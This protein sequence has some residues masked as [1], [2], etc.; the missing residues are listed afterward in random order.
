[1]RRTASCALG[2]LSIVA[3]L[4]LGCGGKHGSG[5]DADTLCGGT[6]CATGEVCRYDRCIAPPA[7]CVNGACSG[8]TCCDTGANECL[9]YGLGPC[10]ANDTACKHTPVPG[11]FFPGVQC[12]WL[13]PPAGDKY[14]DHKNV[15]STPMVATLNGGGAEFTQPWIVF[16]SYNFDDGGDESCKGIDPRYFGVIRV[17]DGRDCAQIATID[18]P[19]VVASSSLALADIGGFDAFPEFIGARTDGGLAAWSRNPATGTWELLWQTASTVGNDVCD[20]AG[21]SV[22]DLD[23]DGKPEILFLGSVFD[24]N[25]KTLDESLTTA[26][27][28]PGANG[29]IPVVADVDGDGGVELVS[30]AQLY[31]WDIP[32]HK[33]VVKGPALGQAGRVAVADLGTYGAVAAND[34][35]SKLDGVA[36]VVVI[37]APTP[38]QGHAYVYNLAGRKVFEAV[39]QGSPPG[40]GG[41]PTVADFD[42]DGRAEFASAGGTAYTVFDPDC[43]AGASAANCASGRTDGVLW[44]QPSQDKSSNVTG[45]SVFDFDGDGTAEVVYG[46]E[47][48]TRVYNGKTGDVEY[49][50][51][52]RSCTWF[53]NPVIADVDADYNAEIL[54]PSNTNCPN[55]IT[56]PALDPIFDGVKCLDDADCPKATH[57]GRD[58]SGDALGKCRCTADPDC[59]GDNF[60]CRDPIAGPAAAGKVC[61]AENPGPSTAFG[62]RVISD[63]LDRWGNTRPIWNQHAYSVTNISDSGIVP[64]TSQWVRNWT[65]A[66]LNNFRQNAPSAD[67]IPGASPDLTVHQ[68]KA[69]CTGPDGTVTVEICDRGTEP[70][71]DGIKISV[72]AGDPPGALACVATT[73]TRVFPGNCVTASCTWANAKGSATIVVDDDGAGAGANSECREDNNRMVLTDVACA[74]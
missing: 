4:S 31:G 57:C 40:K 71:A 46:D 37:A 42:G 17:I 36:E 39:L 41:P 24:A 9:P 5:P 73:A 8:D 50:R 32:N 61:R 3:S 25:G 43:V 49:S 23:D 74:P 68:A 27:L 66:G 67:A 44:F 45:S 29:Y 53:E 20:W 35:R 34:D 28:E 6:T 70:V 65:V 7:A 16:V 2:I 12:E 62:L 26:T 11:V 14:P 59:G 60:V 72:Y 52:R 38:G 64:R 54:V 21:P 55:T 33:W 69:T 18:T 63:R 58:A 56:C 51:F 1:M 30:G 13:G 15:L 48:F 47:C 10:G 19:T 22:H